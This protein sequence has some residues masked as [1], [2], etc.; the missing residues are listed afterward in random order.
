MQIKLQTRLYFL[1]Q[2]VTCGDMVLGHADS[3][4]M[5]RV[6]AKQC[7]FP[8]SYSCTTLLC[9]TGDI[10]GKVQKLFIS[11]FLLGFQEYGTVYL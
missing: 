3:I 11:R 8:A 5:S 2:P 7:V 9:F 4:L 6:P 10:K 1:Q